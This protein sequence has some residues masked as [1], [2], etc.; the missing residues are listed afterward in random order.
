MPEFS[1]QSVSLTPAIREIK[2]KI[3]LHDLFK[4]YGMHESTDSH[5]MICPFHEETNAS[6]HYYDESD[7]L[8]CF[9][10]SK[11]WDLVD[12][13]KDREN[14]SLNEAVIGLSRLF[15]I[16]LAG[17]SANAVPREAERFY[18]LIE[19][20]SKVASPTTRQKSLH[21]SVSK[22]YH[23]PWRCDFVEYARYRLNKSMLSSPT[24]GEI[25]QVF[26]ELRS[27]DE[28]LSISG[29]DSDAQIAS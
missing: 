3:R 12:F 29:G 10:C 19:K 7:S 13:Y 11:S 16:D 8:H 5:Q 14:I 17:L 15:N 27:I 26:G 24:I 9:A 4:F 21:L 25:M 2:S 1:T 28:K 23:Y 22:M 18:K 6:A 20:S